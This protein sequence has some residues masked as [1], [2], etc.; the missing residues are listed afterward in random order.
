MRKPKVPSWPT[1]DCRHSASRAV[2]PMSLALQGPPISPSC[3]HSVYSTLQLAIMHPLCT[4]REPNPDLVLPCSY[5]G[6]PSSPVSPV[7]SPPPIPP[8]PLPLLCPP[9]ASL[10]ANWGRHLCFVDSPANPACPHPPATCYHRHAHAHTHAHARAPRPT[11]RHARNACN[12]ANAPSHP[13]APSQLLRPVSTPTR[14]PK[15]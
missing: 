8:A 6:A 7:T 13:L 10:P 11:L 5:P 9:S 14:V 1:S 15:P 4:Q 12:Q 2:G 3:T